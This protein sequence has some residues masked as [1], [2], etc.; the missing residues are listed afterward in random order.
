MSKDNA[1]APANA[2]EQ[3]A[4]NDVDLVT[5]TKEQLLEGLEPTPQAP[6]EEDEADEAEGEDD[7]DDED[8]SGSEPEAESEDGEDDEEGDESAEDDESDEEEDEEEE[9]AAAPAP[10]KLTKEQIEEL[11]VSN[12]Q[13]LGLK[14]RQGQKIHD[15]DQEIARLNNELAVARGEKPQTET[16]REEYPQT[17]QEW[18]DLYTTDPLKAQHLFYK[19]QREQ[20]QKQAEA[21][22][23]RDQAQ[24]VQATP[25]V[26][27]DIFIRERGIENFDKWS[28]TK[29]GLAV[30]E[31]IGSNRTTKLAM[32]A[33]INTGD[34]EGVAE[35]LGNGLE[36]VRKSAVNKKGKKVEK[37]T[38]AKVDASK[39]R[40]LPRPSHRVHPVGD[41]KPTDYTKEE[42]LGM[43]NKQYRRVFGG[44]A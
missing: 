16:V 11:W 19:M 18:E 22:R 9:A 12:Q 25:L 41:K 38:A 7:G 32:L 28:D 20:E 5:M 21:D 42:I 27:A 34:A 8:G 17:K 13:L 14:G 26:G 43:S 23:L 29:E 39:P 1:A 44:L 31:V 10:T 40:V 2:D 15:K 6:A 36:V 33:A 37:V 35:I 4:T 24:R 30:L 3:G